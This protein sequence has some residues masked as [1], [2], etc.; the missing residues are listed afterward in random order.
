MLKVV[1]A[2]ALKLIREFLKQVSK[3]QLERIAEETEVLKIQWE[4]IK[5]VKE[6]TTPTAAWPTFHEKGDEIT[7]T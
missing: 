7:E 5:Q 6:T 3:G 1:T 2:E 4:F